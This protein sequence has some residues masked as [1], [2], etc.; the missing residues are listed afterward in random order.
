V[1]AGE[2]DQDRLG[3]DPGGHNCF[4]RDGHGDLVSSDALR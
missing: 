4:G 3:C 2:L 1:N